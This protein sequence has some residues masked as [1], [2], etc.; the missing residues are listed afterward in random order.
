MKKVKKIIPYLINTTI[1]LTIFL[2]VLKINN[3]YPFGNFELARYDAYF[4]YKPMLY[5][6]ITS[7][8]NG[9]ISSF[10]FLNGL[11]NPT[12]FNYLYYLA[13]PI[14]LVALF[15]KTPEAMFAAVVLT[16][17]ALTSIFSIFYFKKKTNNNFISTTCAIAYTFT[18]WLTVYYFHIMWLDAFM[19]F[20]LL[21]YGLEKLINENKIYIYIFSLAYIMLTNFYM[22]FM[23]C[24]Y[25]LIYYLYNIIIK[26]DK[27][28]NKVK[29]FQLIMFS[30]IITCLLC[31]FTLYA[32]YSSFLKMGIY[33]SSTAEETAPLK[34]LDFL[35]SFFP[36]N[37]NVNTTQAI[38][39][40]SNISLNIILI[41][42]F[43]YYFLNKKIKLKEKIT[44]LIAIL[45]STFVLFSS[46]MNFI[47]NCFHIPAGY[48]YRYSFVISFYLLI[49]FIRNYK[50][51]ENK[52]D[53]KVYIVNI[54]LLIILI[55][56]LLTKNMEFN[57]FIFNLVF[58]LSYT[59][60]LLLYNNN[61][62]YK[63]ILLI[64]VIVESIISFHINFQ[65][66]KFEL[67]T[68][69]YSSEESPYYR[70]KIDSEVYFPDRINKNL[71]SNDSTLETF[72][73]MQYNNVVSLL[74]ALGCKTDY[75]AT[76]SSCNNTQVFNML[77]NVNDEYNL[78]KIYAVNSNTLSSNIYTDDFIENQNNLVE[79]MTSIENII[80]KKTLTPIKNYTYKITKEDNYIILT[81]FNIKYIKLNNTLYT[82]ETKIPKE[83]E[84]YT[85]KNNLSYSNLLVLNLKENDKLEITYYEEPETNELILYTI[86]EYKI[87]Q[88]HE[89]LENGSINYTHYSNSKIEGTINVEKNQLIFTSIPYDDS[90]NITVDGNIIKPIMIL[91][92]LLGI[93]VEQGNH[94]IKLEYKNNFLVSIIISIST[95]VCLLISL[96]I[97]K[98][99]R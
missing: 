86:D 66:K 39:N 79:G 24:I 91:D 6:F 55:I 94:T 75:K 69:I 15:F 84:S 70:K 64:L 57:I 72:S 31:A 63:Y 82:R 33:I 59:V 52:I 54:I 83:Y 60:F 37:A 14:N 2:I 74:D 21:Q 85:I 11:G 95:L 17:I 87:K 89:I 13:S 65:A 30:T 5:N 88:A 61:K 49:I 77:F 96:V 78:P 10:N 93:E 25:V 92:G 73:S 20:P 56:E 58:L 23:I 44:T 7:I 62:I 41:I 51:F 45:F 80:T 53:I 35:K 19:I 43:L 99:Q 48:S 18:G 3:I 26:K 68:N 32:T 8:K 34:F 46:K 76:I 97:N 81:D 16:K 36:G 38:K 90:W 12:I 50:T 42:S 29:N 27:Y 67:P 9:T 4:Q 22:A 98:K 40:I 47:L 1:V 28:I 71:Y